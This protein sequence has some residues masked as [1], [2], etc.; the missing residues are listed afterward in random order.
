MDY[1]L[2]ISVT[3]INFEEGIISISQELQKVVMY[4]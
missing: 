2:D 1:L 4:L 3:V